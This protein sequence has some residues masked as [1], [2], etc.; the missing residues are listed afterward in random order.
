MRELNDNGRQEAR[1][2]NSTYPKGGVLCFSDTFVVAESSVL[3][4]EFSGKNPATSPNCKTLGE[5][6]TNTH[7]NEPY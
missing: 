7:I 1:T 3:R 5:V 2:A 6:L 4:M